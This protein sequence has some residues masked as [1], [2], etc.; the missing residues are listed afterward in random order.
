[1]QTGGSLEVGDTVTLRILDVN[2]SNGIIELTAKEDL[3]DYSQSQK[4][5]KGE[6]KKSKEAAVALPKVA[7]TLYHTARD[8]T[9]LSLHR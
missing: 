4:Q 5:G 8:I 2:K 6:A 3:L 9:E 7:T 1:M